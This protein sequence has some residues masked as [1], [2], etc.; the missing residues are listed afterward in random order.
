MLRFQLDR[1]IMV[2]RWRKEWEVH[3][4]DFGK[5]HCGLGIGT[6]RKHRIYEGHSPNQHCT[7]CVIEAMEKKQ[8][9][10]RERYSAR[11]Y[12]QQTLNHPELHT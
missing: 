9:G 1:P 3:G 10:R 6:M 11:N 7:G 5:C 2:K 4:R 8:N 12:I